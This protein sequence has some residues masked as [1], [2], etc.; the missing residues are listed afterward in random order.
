LYLANRVDTRIGSCIICVLIMENVRTM[1]NE[2]ILESFQKTFPDCWAKPGEDWGG[3]DSCVIWTG[4]GSD[5]G[6]E[7]AFNMHAH[8]NSFGVHPAI[9][10]WAKQ[11]GVEF[12]A[13][14]SST[15]F[16]YRA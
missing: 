16:A 1:T 2:Q 6:D 5:V 14:D 3:D 4:E 12:H 7:Y 9:V 13:Y 15:F 10:K 11:N 8:V